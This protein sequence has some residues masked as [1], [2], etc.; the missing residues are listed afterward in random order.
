MWR[1]VKIKD[2]LMSRRTALLNPSIAVT[3]GLLLLL[4][5]YL[6]TDLQAAEESP[7]ADGEATEAWL[8]F[9]LLTEGIAD[10]AVVTVG[11]MIHVVGGLSQAGPTGQ[12]W[13]FDPVAQRWQT[14]PPLPVPRSDAVSALIG[15]TLYVAGGY[16]MWYGGALSYTHSYNVI[17][18]AWITTT[19]LIT[20]VSGAASVVVNDQLIVLGGFDN[21][22]ESASVQRYDPVTKEWHAGRAMPVARSEFDAVLLDDLIYV[23][24]GNIISHDTRGQTLA[25]TDPIPATL[26]SAYDPQR[27][28]WQTMA[29]LP[30]PRIDFTARVRD[31]KIYVIGGTDR[32]ITGNAQKDLFIYDPLLNEWTQ[33]PL[34][35]TAR[36]G[37]RSTR[38]QSTIFV[39][40]GYNDSGA[41]LADVSF[42]DTIAST[43]FLP[44]ISR[45]Q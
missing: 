25:K 8:S 29:P 5:L 39:I 15:D 4:S 16:N 42:L 3:L 38:W 20:P 13:Q 9:P 31:G 11:S 33:G 36:A 22:S 7:L 40:G 26:V 6:T 41:P 18:Q 17:T 23:I 19:A 45:E 35:P 34:L 10:P 14:L 12:H 27:E 21:R 28:E 2:P 1:Y 44:V 37:L 32:W 43:I 30:A 24:G